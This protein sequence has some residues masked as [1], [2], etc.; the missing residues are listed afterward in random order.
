[1]LLTYAA[2]FSLIPSLLHAPNELK[3]NIFRSLYELMNL[4]PITFFI[5]PISPYIIS[6]F[7]SP[8]SVHKFINRS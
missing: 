7:F 3:I 5:S 6:L 4:F 8:N 2:C 1:M